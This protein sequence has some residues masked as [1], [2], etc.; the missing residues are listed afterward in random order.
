MSIVI[1]SRFTALTLRRLSEGSSSEICRQ[2]K[3]DLP[4]DR[5]AGSTRSDVAERRLGVRDARPPRPFER[6][7]RRQR[8]P[9]LPEMR[10]DV[11]ER[12]SHLAVVSSLKGEGDELRNARQMSISPSSSSRACA[13]RRACSF[14]IFATVPS[15][16]VRGRTS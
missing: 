11:R 16:Q 3:H 7:N 15:Q 1:W 5:R 2:A 10:R 13:T 6:G 14:V 8:E 9:L 4:D 12:A